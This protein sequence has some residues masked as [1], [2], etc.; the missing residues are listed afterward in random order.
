MTPKEGCDRHAPCW[1]PLFQSIG[2][3]PRLGRVLVPGEKVSSIRRKGLR[4]EPTGGWP[5]DELFVGVA[6]LRTT[7]ELFRREREPFPGPQ[8]AWDLAL[9]S[10]V[11]IQG[12]AN[13]L[14]R[15]SRLGLLK[16]F[17]SDRAGHATAF[18]L[19]QTHPLVEP[20]ARL[21]QAERAFMVRK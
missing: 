17:P 5:L 7:R 20:L 12:S 4:R 3:V 11:S 9:W 10:G 21:F 19:D 14:E 1:R 8:R 6:T 16:V 15:L 18:R 2:T 13:S